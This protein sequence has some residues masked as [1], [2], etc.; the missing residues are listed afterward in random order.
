MSR[1]KS[2]TFEVDFCANLLREGIPWLICQSYQTM[3]PFPPASAVLEVTAT[4]PDYNQPALRIKQAGSAEARPRSGSMTRILTSSLSKPVSG[5]SQRGSLRLPCRRTNSRSMAAMRANEVSKP[6]SCFAR[7][8]AGAISV[9]D[10]RKPQSYESLEKERVS[11]RSRMPRLRRRR[12]S[13]AVGFCMWRTGGSPVSRF[14][15]NG[16]SYRE[17]KRDRGGER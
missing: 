5:R 11:S 1:P 3:A 15:W 17:S 4:N 8:V 12:I 9:S 16:H 10:S 6:L 2:G 13:L 7:P 14:E